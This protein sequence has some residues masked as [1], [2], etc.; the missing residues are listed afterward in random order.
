MHRFIQFCINTNIIVAIAALALYKIT[1]ILFGFTDFQM[2][3]FI[4]FSTLFAYNYMRINLIID[5]KKTNC[6][7]NLFNKYRKEV[8]FI[9]VT[10]AFFTC[11]CA[12]LLGFILLN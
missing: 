6:Q 11:W 9:L 4:F 2:S 10:S 3:F 7:S 12:Y 8:F 1:E 5:S